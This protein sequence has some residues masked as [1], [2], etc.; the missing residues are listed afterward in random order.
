MTEEQA[1]QNAFEQETLKAAITVWGERAQLE[2]AQEEATELALAVRK[3]I[4]RPTSDRLEDLAGEM[5]DVE[6]MISQLKM[7]LPSTKQAVKRIK[8]EKLARLVD[9]LKTKSFEG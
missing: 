6:L 4:R 9:R 8:K 3:F 5:A 2:M 1:K 7:M